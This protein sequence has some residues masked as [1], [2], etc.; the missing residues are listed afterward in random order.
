MNAAL[1]LHGPPRAR[2]GKGRRRPLL[3]AALVLLL[4]AATGAGL[5]RSAQSPPATLAQQVAAVAGGLRCPTCAGQSVAASESDLAR[6]MR[7]VAAQQLSAGRSPE[8]VRAWFAQRYG[9]GVLLDP[10]LRGAGLAVRLLPLAVVGVGVA[11]LVRAPRRRRAG[12]VAGTVAVTAL[13]TSAPDLLA[14]PG[15]TKPTGAA[16]AWAVPPPAVPEAA[17]TAG[18]GAAPATIG[19]GAAPAATGTGAAGVTSRRTAS[20]QQALRALQRGDAAEAER[21][22]RIGLGEAGSNGRA[23]QDA[24]LV[25]GLAQHERGEADA[26]DTL[27]AFLAAAPTHPAAAR[28]RQLLDEGR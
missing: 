22:A 18:S 12:W 17:V 23:A 5:W 6:Q 16:S 24:L 26:R 4:V 9:D 2:P 1:P 15:T 8:Q 25:L 3:F 28:V 13:L 21:L 19:T 11:F 20:T 27:R 10:P 7:A 14:R